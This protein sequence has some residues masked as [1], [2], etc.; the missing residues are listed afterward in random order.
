[1]RFMWFCSQRITGTKSEFP[2]G[3]EE[4]VF[5]ESLQLITISYISTSV[6][7]QTKKLILYISIPS[8][9]KTRQPKVTKRKNKK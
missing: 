4:N 2:L 3:E 1:M 5:K 6:Q 7:M 9:C 8:N